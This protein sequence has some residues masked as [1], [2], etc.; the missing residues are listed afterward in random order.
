MTI[1]LGSRAADPEKTAHAGKTHRDEL[2]AGRAESA[3]FP[4]CAERPGRSSVGRG[5]LGRGRPDD[6]EVLTA[7]DGANRRTGGGRRARR[8]RSRRCG[9][10]RRPRLPRV[11]PVE[12]KRLLDQR[13][14]AADLMPERRHRILVQPAGPDRAARCSRP[15]RAARCSGRSRAAGRSGPAGRE[16]RSRRQRRRRGVDDSAGR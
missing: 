10:S 15:D 1:V 8:G 6:G 16:G 12:R 14:R 7:T 4:H 2:P 3:G 11:L 9:R 13:E 5:P